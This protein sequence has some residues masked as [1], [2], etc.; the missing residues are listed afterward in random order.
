[1]LKRNLKTFSSGYSLIELIITIVLTSIV[2][3]IFY[4]VFA[5]NQ[6]KSASPV[7]QVKAAELAQAYLEEISLRRFH[8]NSPA[9]NTPPCNSPA[10]PPCTLFALGGDGEARAQFD[11]VDDYHFL[12]EQPP[13]DALGNPRNGFNGFRA[14]VN[15]SYAG[16]DFGLPAQDLKRIE[17]TITI[18]D[19][20]RWVFSSYKGNF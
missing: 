6:V 13:Q 1:M 14:Q 18:P 7:M 9:G 19:G 8:E 3:V 17:V 4:G 20:S 15:V 5:Q 12:D 2:M 16:V 10:A 11:D